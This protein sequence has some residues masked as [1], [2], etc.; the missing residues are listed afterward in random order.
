MKT[1][2]SSMRSSLWKQMIW[3]ENSTTRTIR[4]AATTA[5]GITTI[6]CLLRTATKCALLFIGGISDSAFSPS[7]LFIS[8]GF[9]SSRR[10]PPGRTSS[11]AL[12]WGCAETASSSFAMCCGVFSAP[13]SASF[14]SSTIAPHMIDSPIGH[15]FHLLFRRPEFPSSVYSILGY[16]YSG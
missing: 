4:T 1:D 9:G 5:T 2:R 11:F 8:P 10:S 13:I 12:E 7:S 14:L 6:R 3:V 15:V 16:S